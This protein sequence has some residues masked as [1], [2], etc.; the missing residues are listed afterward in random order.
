MA[1]VNIGQLVQ[2]PSPT[3]PPTSSLHAYG[4]QHPTCPVLRLAQ[5]PTLVL[6]LSATL[7][8]TMN[9]FFKADAK[10][11]EQVCPGQVVARPKLTAEDKY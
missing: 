7:A 3:I 4:S 1:S 2:H 8:A 6:T 10:P 11:P 5:V 9:K